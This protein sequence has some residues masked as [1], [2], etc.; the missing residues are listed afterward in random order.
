MQK[1]LYCTLIVALLDC[2]SGAIVKLEYCLHSKTPQKLLFDSL[3][4]IFIL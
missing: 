2:K 3:E 4:L 1:S